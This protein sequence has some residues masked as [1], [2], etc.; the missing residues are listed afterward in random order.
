VRSYGNTRALDLIRDAINIGANG[1]AWHHKHMIWCQAHGLQ[2]HKRL[3]RYESGED[4]AWYIKLQN[5]ALD[6]F[7]EA[8]EPDW[9]YAISAPM[10]IKGYLEGYLDW[11]NSV[12]SRLASISNDL[13]VAGFPCEADIVLEGMPRKEIERVRRMLT[14]Y[15]LSGWDMSYILI[16]DRELHEKVKTME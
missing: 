14:E 11:E 6:M 15:A 7:G 5:Y 12:Y 13:V 4:R 9:D 10:D 2:G 8:I 1:E 16:R 3:N